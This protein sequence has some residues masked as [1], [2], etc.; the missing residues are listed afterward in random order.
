MSLPPI[1]LNLTYPDEKV[2]ETYIAMAAS[3]GIKRMSIDA[4]TLAKMTDTPEFARQVRRSAE[5][6]NI[7]FFDAHAP[8]APVDSLGNPYPGG[9][10]HSTGVM[11]RSLHAAAEAGIKILTMHT[12]RT[13]LVGNYAPETGPIMDLDLDGAVERTLR[14]LDVL[15][16]EA[17]KLGMII[18]LENIVLPSSTA[19]HIM[20]IL[21]KA[22]HPHLGLCY[23]AGHALIME[24][25]PDKDL[26]KIAGWIRCGWPEDTVVCQ[27]DQLDIMLNEIVT[28]HLHDND[29]HGDL[30]LLPGDG[31]A[32]WQ[33]IT[34]RLKR[35]PRL[36]SL[37]SEV[38][39]HALT[40]DF[41]RT[42]RQFRAAGFPVT[43][44]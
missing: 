6:H 10:E 2:M 23:D 7:A 33:K 38:E 43:G 41:A 36:L 18:A 37:Q 19:E 35:A 5:A 17:E 39:H 29:G 31:I 21:E 42:L 26:T 24:R 3:L 22:R 12:A 27:E 14:Q 9:V 13:R 8:H 4:V 28:T 32:D 16:P 40:A 15:I 25:Q 11:L 30:H 44:E 1:A 20:R 34:E